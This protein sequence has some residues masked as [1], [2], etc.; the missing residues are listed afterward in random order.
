[1]TSRALTRVERAYMSYR[2]RI[3]I[4]ATRV[5]LTSVI[6]H[7]AMSTAV[8]QDVNPDYKSFEKAVLD[9]RDV[10]LILD[11]SRCTEHGVE[12]RGP[13]VRGSIRFDAYM[14]RG[15]Q[16]VAFAITHFTLRSDNTAVDE[17]LSFRVYPNGKVNVRTA[18]L[19]PITFSVTQESQFDC[20]IGEGATFHW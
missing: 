15:D 10:R 18:F 17:F 19:N 7:A 2:D 6:W 13:Q 8:A 1:M 12:A 20:D 11:L 16:T 3:F 14:I 5:V 9:G 4:F